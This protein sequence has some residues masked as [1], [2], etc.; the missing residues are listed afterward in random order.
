MRRIFSLLLFFA[1]YSNAFADYLVFY[2]NG[3]AGLRDDSGKVIIPASFDALGWADGSFSVINQ[4]TGFRQNTKWGLINLKKEFVTKAVYETVT[5]SGGDRVVASKQI[6]P[7]TVK[8]GCLD[9]TG[10]ITVPFIYDGISIVG[11]RAI[12]FV[13]NGTKYEHGL[14]DLDDKSILPVRYRD[15]HPIGSLRFAI[16]N[17]DRKTALYS[18]AGIQL[19]DF[20]ID[21]I[22]AFKKGSAVIYQNLQQG[23]IDREGIVQIPP[24]YR[25]LR[26]S[27]NG[28]EGKTSDSWK[29]IDTNNKEITSIEGDGLIADGS[30][31]IV[32]HAGKFGVVD[33]SLNKKIDLKYDGLDRFS[34]NLSVAR[35]GNKF[36]LVSL[37]GNET[38]AFEFDSLILEG[39]FV[40]AM[41]KEQGW[42]QWS[43]YDTF[44]VKKT[45]RTYEELHKF[46]GRFFPVKNRG[47]W[48]VV[49][50]YGKEV[51][52]CVYD[53]IVGFNHDAVNVKF[54]G[55]YGLV[56][57]DARWRV[58]PQQHPLMQVDS[59]VYLEK[60]D[61]IFFLKHV[62][63]QVI[64]VSS[65][66]LRIA[67]DRY[68]EEYCRDGTVRL[69]TLDGISTTISAPPKVDNTDDIFAESE[70]MRG[71]R[72]DGRYGFI[73]SRGRL[74]IANRYEGIGKFREGLAPIMLIGKWG[75]VDMEDRI[76]INPNFETASE[77]RNGI[78]VVRR[79]GKSGVIGKEGQFIVP[80]R[81]DSIARINSR[82]VLYDQNRVGLADQSG[83][84]LIEP[85]F[86]HL[87]LLPNNLVIVRN[88]E[89][90]GVLSIDGMPVVPII[91]SLI[92]YNPA[93]NQ[94][95]ANKKS[96][97]RSISIS[98][99]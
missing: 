13:K 11:L 24:T 87:E 14:I 88:D 16:Q 35:R 47:F 54:K 56:G 64:Y 41:K 73:D 62:S 98:K 28:I 43:V 83:H 57:F 95:L 74:R 10:K 33:E 30:H 15:I 77:F 68:L 12:V 81:Y 96:E 29:I 34:N 94:F 50:R 82:L 45:E 48:G 23:L 17:F 32:S 53:S 93:A 63:G 3:K 5:S 72:R 71:I 92:K 18:E 19:T 20:V 7:Y 26:I 4:V 22:S 89:K 52:S 55:L 60:Q 58:L 38:F 69:V 61:S 44:N 67:A 21:S 66:D 6:N 2:E 99:N 8:Y 31:Y 1:A 90:W 39:P 40:R 65:N 46:N 76:V 51:L 75:F 59:E 25:D 37:S 9:L 86:D 97:W 85:R 42:I 80:L 84:V 91:Y 78:A 70:G 79:G 49:D 27:E 36:G